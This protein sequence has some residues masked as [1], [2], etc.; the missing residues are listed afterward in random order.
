MLTIEIPGSPPLYL[1]HLV[2]DY[3]GTLAIDGRLLPTVADLLNALSSHLTVHVITADTFGTAQAALT[4]VTC[5][6]GILPPGRQDEAKR[7]YVQQLGAAG[8]VA[9]GNGRNDRLMLQTVALGIAVMQAE[10]TAVA[11]LTAAHIL[12]P[13]IQDALHLLREPRRLI[14]TLRQ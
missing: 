6:L 14:A 12:I 4:G 11:T 7:D 13:T 9:I 2:L 1:H 8:C 10:G 3:N 5:Q